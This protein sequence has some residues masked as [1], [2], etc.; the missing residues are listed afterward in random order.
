M[1]DTNDSDVFII[2][3]PPLWY[4]HLVVIVDL[5]RVVGIDETYD[6]YVDDECFD[7]HDYNDDTDHDTD[8]DTDDKIEDDPNY[9]TDDDIDDGGRGTAILYTFLA[10]L[11]HSEKRFDY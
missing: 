10:V 1:N 7:N 6:T 4:N 8:D 5:I 3:A 9:F 11:T 2:M